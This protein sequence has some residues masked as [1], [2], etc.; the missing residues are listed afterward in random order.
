MRARLRAHALL[1]LQ[2]VTVGRPG[3][4][5]SARDFFVAK[6]RRRGAAV[7]RREV[8]LL[9]DLV[10]QQCDLGQFQTLTSR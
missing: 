8:E 6:V 3:V 4:R 9:R 10:V 5:G 2:Q 7:L 1:C